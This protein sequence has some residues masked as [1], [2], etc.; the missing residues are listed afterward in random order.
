MGYLIVKTFYILNY[1]YIIHFKISK[2]TYKSILNTMITQKLSTKKFRSKYRRH[3]NNI[4]AI[5]NAK[6]LIKS[7]LFYEHFLYPFKM[8]MFLYN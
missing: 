4:K 5:S 3:I 8:S 6:L 7:R 1:V 2:R